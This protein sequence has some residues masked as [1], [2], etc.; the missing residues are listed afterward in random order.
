MS[1][2]T[3]I[4]Q[5]MT[6]SH[7]KKVVWI[8]VRVALAA[9]LLS[10]ALTSPAAAQIM[11][12]AAW[13]ANA[14]GSTVGYMVSVGTSPG[15]T[16][17]TID[18]GP[19]TNAVLPLAPGAVYYISVRAYN[20]QR[21]TG[22]PSVEAAVDLASSPGA[23]QGL[24]ASVAGSVATLAW[25]PPNEGFATRY[26]LSVGTA[27]GADNLLSEYP[28]GNVTSVS[29]A[30]PPGTYYA[31]VQ[32]ANVVGVGPTTGAVMFRVGASI[33]VPAT[34]SALAA[35]WANGAVTLSWRASSGATSYALEVGSAPGAA[36]LGVFNVGNVTAYSAA[37]PVGTYYVRVRGLN[38]GGSSAP[39]NEVVL[40]SV[41]VAVPGAPRNL[42]SS[43]S[44]ATVTLAWAAPSS[45][46][47]PTSYV[48]E[49]GSASGQTDVGVFSVGAVTAITTTAPPG[50]YYVRV[51]AANG[52]G[53][54]AASNTVVVRR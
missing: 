19:A 46:G 43:G 25:A 15:A 45:G 34:P 47:A 53:V 24:H 9:L 37:V 14:D 28:V 17:Q 44:G 1:P 27:P 5:S 36:D 26:L 30:L 38:A 42:T 21:Q 41:P 8:R 2:A 10:F 49:V 29:G 16:T 11:V 18:A 48:V 6:C 31:R 39:S 54:G 22:P 7:R 23:P 33:A 3:K 12:T 50:T 51:R 4:Q 13:D 20:A 40:Q 35:T 32:A 52:S